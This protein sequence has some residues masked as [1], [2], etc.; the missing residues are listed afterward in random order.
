M[1]T[2]APE[3][4]I[5]KCALIKSWSV[6][7]I[8]AFCGYM[9]YSKTLHCDGEFFYVESGR[10]TL[11]E[12]MGY[13]INSPSD[14]YDPMISATG[15]SFFFTST[16]G[17]DRHE[18][19]FISSRIMSGWS[20]PKHIK[21]S[22]VLSNVGSPFISY[23]NTQLYFTQCSY[24]GSCDIYRAVKSGDS[25]RV[26]LVGRPISTRR[27]WEAHPSLSPD[28]RRLFFSSIRRGG[29]GGKDIYM[30]RRTLRGWSSPVPLN[31]INT[32]GDEVSPYIHIDGHTLYFSSDG[33]DDGYG[34]LDFYV[35]RI[36]E[37]GK[38]SDIR[39][40]GT[41]INDSSEQ[42][43]IRTSRDGRVGYYATNSYEGGSGG[44]DIY[45]YEL[46]K[47]G[48]ATPT[49][50]L[51]GEIKNTE[52]L[53]V[54]YAAV[55]IDA[56]PVPLVTITGS[57]YISIMGDTP[58]IHLQCTAAGYM[59]Y[60]TLLY[61]NTSSQV[62]YQD[63]ILRPIKIG[64]RYK[65]NSIHFSTD[66]YTLDSVSMR[67]VERL[68]VFMMENP[69]VEIDVE[70]H[71]DSRG[72]ESYNFLLSSRRAN[73]IVEAL[74]AF[75]VDSSRMRAVP[76]GDTRPLSSSDDEMSMALNRRCEILVRQYSP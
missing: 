55:Y 13:P 75:G 35:C 30:S 69:S 15:E 66:V 40:M 19:I 34:K 22:S 64:A 48:R 29:K 54:M 5:H 51:L 37:Y 9:S 59:P 6:I 76:Y 16:R 14:D 33:Y 42:Y 25:W 41:S 11:Y 8:M 43:S 20:T 21:L 71:T 7:I 28:G 10:D 53:E 57:K 68:A 60:D 49:S 56:I 70:G 39:N 45:R 63:I 12:N 61:P 4:Q 24:G 32:S 38:C 50:I 18:R 73:S 23:D 1:E 27:H 36:D 26:E 67:Q 46:E 74:V 52:N 2:F 62:M 17:E 72:G 31:D 47:E 58:M 65:L 3:S 44:L